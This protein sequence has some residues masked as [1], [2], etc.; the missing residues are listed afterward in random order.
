[1][2]TKSPSNKV[3][4]LGTTEL[5]NGIESKIYLIREQRVMLSTDLA[6]LYGVEPKVLMQA[7]SRNLDRFP[8]DF[9]FYITNQE[10]T[11]L[12]SQTVT[13]NGR[14]GR[15]RSQPFAF[16]EQGVAMLSGILNSDKAINMNIAIVRAFIFLRQL[17]TQHKDLASQLNQLRQEMYDRFGDHDTQLAAIYNAIEKML[18]QYKHF[19]NEL[20]YSKREKLIRSMVSQQSIKIGKP[21][22]EKELQSVVEGLFACSYPN[23]TADGAPTYIEFRKEYLMNL[24]RS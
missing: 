22:T 11:N 10:F 13:S 8:P 24:F 18:E 23:T 7:V 2:A 14:G 6:E 3:L 5:I 17:A 19:S 15:R 4:S 16:T 20:K 1:M 12:K 21:L 9:S